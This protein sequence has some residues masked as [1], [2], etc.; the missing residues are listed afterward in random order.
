MSLTS[1][2]GSQEMVLEN[3]VNV[4]LQLPGFA[5]SRVSGNMGYMDIAVPPFL[6]LGTFFFV[7]L[8]EY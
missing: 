2:K 5:K 6:L 1:I 7:R 4:L 3:L 8:L